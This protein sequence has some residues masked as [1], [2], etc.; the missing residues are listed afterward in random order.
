MRKK[1]LS[2]NQRFAIV[3][4]GY[5]PD[6][7]ENY[8]RVEQ[9][10]AQQVQMEQKERIVALKGQC[11]ELTNEVS[12]LK[13][14]EEQIKTTLV[15]ATEKAE[16]MS[17]DIKLRYNAE[18]KRLQLFRS[19]WEHAYD[20]IKE[21]YHFSKDTLNMESVAVSIKLEIEK[22]LAQDFSLDR[23]DR[24]DAFEQHFMEEV[25]RLTLPKS[26]VEALKA[27]LEEAQKKKEIKIS[28]LNNSKGS[29]FSMDSS[30]PNNALGSGVD[31]FDFKIVNK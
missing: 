29:L 28:N 15:S 26:E 14:R 4:R 16:K 3:Y 24:S 22:Y 21:R 13:E 25:E 9:A 10:K 18:L 5:D 23:G 11:L 12:K 2:S 19:K 1:T 7:V 17:E 8:V 30:T 27:K 31:Y 6:D 20:E